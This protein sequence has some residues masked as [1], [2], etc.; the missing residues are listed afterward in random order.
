MPHGRKPRTRSTTPVPP[1]PAPAIGRV[2]HPFRALDLLAAVTAVL[3]VAL[4]WMSRYALNPDGVSYLDLAHALQRGDWVHFVQGYWS[5]LYPL[6][7]GAVIRV[8]ALSIAASVVLT[9]VINTV[10]AL[11]ALGMVWWWARRQ[12]R[13]EFGYLAIG[14]FMLVSAGMPRIEAVTP[15]LLLTLVLTWLAYEL[16]VGAARRW[17]MVGLLL[18]A[19]F[20]A[21]TSSWPWLI[22]AAPL[23]WWAF[24]DSRPRVIKSAVMCIAAVMLWAIPMSIRYGRPTVG[25]SGRLNFSWYMRANSSRLPDTDLGGNLTY[26]SVAVAGAAPLT[27][28]V[29]DDWQAWTYQ[30]WGD[31]TAWHDKVTVETGRLPTV[32]E[33][34]LYW[35][36]LTMRVF[37]LWLAPTIVTVL[38]PAYWLQRRPG[39]WREL[40]HERRREGAVAAIGLIGVLQFTAIHAEP[41]L[42]AP[43]AMLWVLGMLAWCYAV[44][45]APA[46]AGRAWLRRIVPWLGVIAALGFAI[47]K[48]HQAVV[49]DVRLDRTVGRLDAMAAKA[50]SIGMPLDRIAIVGAAMPMLNSAYWLG[51][52]VIA[53]MPP[54]SADRFMAMP[55]AQQRA[56]LIRLFG[57]H[58]AMVWQS[59]PNGG[60]QMLVVPPRADTS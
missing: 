30:P 51:A 9:H 11:A 7:I 49:G 21:K 14:G 54:A 10:A 13:P 35:L 53:Q 19:A 26:R 44:P 40:L 56:M 5:P 16:V 28:A 32:V 8:A 47:P 12:T 41:R 22:V 2:A 23:L 3:C 36:R 42:I 59:T 24:A 60:M 1:T 39:M 52:H 27:V 20:L 6:I 17:A 4:G 25:S 29:F 50:A 37:G 55:P 43:F 33:L 31:P 48:F 38:V 18:G 34:V 15:D 45:V 57:G 46:F 58:V